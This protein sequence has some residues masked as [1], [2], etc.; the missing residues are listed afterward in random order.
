M[1]FYKCKNNLPWSFAM[2]VYEGG[3][4]GTQKKNGEIMFVNVSRPFRI[5]VKNSNS[6]YNKTNYPKFSSSSIINLN[7]KCTYS[8]FFKSAIR[9]I[10]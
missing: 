4:K 5:G 10:F 1:D 7:E 3:R 6:G 9:A 8:H 2:L